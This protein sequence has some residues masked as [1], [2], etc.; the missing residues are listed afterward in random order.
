[1]LFGATSGTVKRQF[2]VTSGTVSESEQN[3]V[4]IAR[5]TIAAKTQT[6]KRVL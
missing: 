1:M 4:P 6:G 3:S 5:N 2:A